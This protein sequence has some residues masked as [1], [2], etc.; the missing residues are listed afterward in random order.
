MSHHLTFC[1]AIPAYILES[2]DRNGTPRQRQRA[3]ETLQL[4]RLHR[5]ARRQT[6]RSVRLFRRNLRVRRLELIKRMWAAAIDCEVAREIYDGQNT[7][8]L[9]GRLARSEGE[10]P[11][12]DPAV[13]EV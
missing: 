3:R 11:I 7:Q 4:D 12:D 10:E 13:N 8:K 5:A 6:S 1:S 9:P 2:I